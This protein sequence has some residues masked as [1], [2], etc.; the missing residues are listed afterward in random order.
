MDKM[1]SSGENNNVETSTQS[2][3]SRDTTQGVLAFA[4]LLGC[5]TPTFSL[6]NE[7]SYQSIPSKNNCR[8]ASGYSTKATKSNNKQKSLPKASIRAISKVSLM[9]IEA[10][11]ESDLQKYEEAI[12]LYQA[13]TK[14]CKAKKNWYCAAES[15]FEEGQCLMLLGEFKRAEKPFRLSIE[16]LRNAE[17]FDNFVQGKHLAA[18]A[19]CLRQ[20]SKFNEAA[21][22]FNMAL[23]QMNRA[24]REHKY[25]LTEREHELGLCHLMAGRHKMAEQHLK[26]SIA[27]SRTLPLPEGKNLLS[28]LLSLAITLNEQGRWDEANAICAEGL[29][30]GD[31]WGFGTPQKLAR[32]KSQYAISLVNNPSKTT[33]MLES[34]NEAMKIGQNADGAADWIFG[35]YDSW[36]DALIK[37]KR[38]ELAREWLD[39]GLA[40]AHKDSLSG[41]ES[42]LLLRD[43]A[44]CEIELGNLTQASQCLDEAYKIC[45]AHPNSSSCA[46]GIDSLR[47]SIYNIEQKWEAAVDALN[48]LRQKQVEHL[49][50]A[51]DRQSAERELS[52]T[53]RRLALVLFKMGKVEDADH[54]FKEALALKEK[55]LDSTDALSLA[56]DIQEIGSTYC[57]TERYP[58]A[59]PYLVRALSI[60][61]RNGDESL[62]DYGF[63]GNLTQLALVYI[64]MKDP[65]KASPLVERL[66][67]FQDKGN[68]PS[69]GLDAVSIMQSL[70]SAYFKNGKVEDGNKLLERALALRAKE[71][72]QAKPVEDPIKNLNLIMVK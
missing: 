30:L 61:D 69:P 7:E 63:E 54:N 50:E 48:H 41:H 59:V 53:I 34:I 16:Y 23:N 11:K 26:E 29:K 58:E 62:G 8:I 3:S 44:L 55:N 49:D 42:D 9:M 19:S 32:Y 17:C 6:A 36:A 60:R 37:A 5:L 27:L 51:V 45:S 10:K 4:I 43:K 18:L 28:S 39:K 2:L 52:S 31:E 33:E 68:G 21:G 13:V 70:A 66:F 38:Y 64:A 46:M 65:D 1:K 72:W 40:L 14:R 12:L 15:L 47:A 35:M 57:V 24:E 56:H 20:Q 71:K 22:D 25:Q 67:E